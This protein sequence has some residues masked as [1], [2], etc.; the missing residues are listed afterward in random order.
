MEHVIEKREMIPTR[1]ALISGVVACFLV[2]FYV[3]VI[4]SG[5]WTLWVECSQVTISMEISVFNESF[6]EV[7]LKDGSYHTKEKV[8][9]QKDWLDIRSDDLRLPFGLWALDG[10]W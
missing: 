9:A 5:S 2:F 1:L 4:I 3:L 7:R 8:D 6:L 10:W